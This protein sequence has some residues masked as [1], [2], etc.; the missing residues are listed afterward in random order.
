MQKNKEFTHTQIFRDKKIS[1]KFRIKHKYTKISCISIKTAKTNQKE[2]K[3]SIPFIITSKRIK[4]LGTNLI[5]EVQNLNS[6]KSKSLMKDV[7]KV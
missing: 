6:E 7:K 4:Y 2:I 1:A 5:K 3:K